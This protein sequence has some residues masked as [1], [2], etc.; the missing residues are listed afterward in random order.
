MEK[1][2]EICALY[3]LFFCSQAMFIMH[4]LTEF[5]GNCGA[6]FFL[7]EVPVLDVSDS[8]FFTQ[9]PLDFSPPPF[10][11]EFF[12]LRTAALRSWHT[13]IP[14]ATPPSHDPSLPALLP[15]LPGSNKT[16]A[17]RDIVIRASTPQ[18]SLR[19]PPPFLSA[20]SYP[21][22]SSPIPSLPDTPLPSALHHLVSASSRLLPSR[23]VSR[24]G[25][26][27][28]G[29]RQAGSAGLRHLGRVLGGRLVYKK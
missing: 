12:I 25:F 8:F 3:V 13:Y 9:C 11:F 22:S 6:F 19:V 16:K 10:F 23:L 21:P 7:K 4:A 14:K 27:S 24:A 5:S 2:A 17:I 26:Q 29:S 18:P 20:L 15:T 28:L 1:A